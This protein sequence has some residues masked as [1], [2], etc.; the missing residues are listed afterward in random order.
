MQNRVH[1]H[2]VRRLTQAE[3]DAICARHERL[4]RAQPGGARA[5]F[6]WCDLSGLSLK[7]RNLSDADFSATVMHGTDL[8]GCRLDNANFFGADLQEAD[9][10]G[11]S[12]R[13]ADL[14]GA[15][16]RGAD[17]SGADLFE[18][19]LRE[20]TLAASDREAGFR[21]VKP[22]D[23]AADASGVSLVGANLE[24]SRLAG[25]VAVRA[26]FTDALMRDCKL[27]RAN[28]KQAS[29]AGADLAGADLSGA[30]L[31]GA[32]L[33]DA[34]L[35]GVKSELWRTDGA[36][37]Q[38]VLTDEKSSQPGVSPL[39]AAER[40]GAHSRWCETS[41][42]EGRP[43]VFDGLDLRALKTV[44]GF[45]LTALS[46]KG[47][48]FY[49]LD[50]EGVQLQGAHLEGADLRACKLRGADLRGARLAGARLNGADLRE[51][52]LGPLL[53][54]EDRLLAADLSGAVLRG[55]D[56]AGADLKHARLVQADLR[57]ANLHGAATRLAVFTLARLDGA[58]G[59]ESICTEAWT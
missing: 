31:S 52:H 51:A 29:L 26:D 50:M 20:G 7:G 41:G 25:I 38:G 40:L 58:R 16:L 47:A 57:R 1:S 27:V 34:V 10:S 55:A 4:W 45:N 56:L 48:V 2:E 37:M 9:L 19:D 43:S 12:L 46:A 15:C 21:V 53:I 28:L 14:R 17:L 42:A 18:S 8:S 54:G 23:R 22:A 11:A 3:A 49:G 5:V 59:G 44:R 39:E 24:R 35:V 30:D 32:D 33:T 13:R 36:R 6:G